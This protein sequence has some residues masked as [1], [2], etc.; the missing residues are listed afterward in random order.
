[1][2]V[3]P[4]AHGHAVDLDRGVGVVDDDAPRAFD[5]D[6][7]RLAGVVLQQDPFQAAV[8]VQRRAVRH[9]RYGDRRREGYG[10]GE[11]YAGHSIA[12]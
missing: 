9:G 7:V 5:R 6:Q 11:E 4:H 1:V 12:P 3:D 8:L 2:G 10:G